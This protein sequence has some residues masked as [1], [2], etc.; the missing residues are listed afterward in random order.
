MWTHAAAAV[1][2]TDRMKLLCCCMI[3]MKK[4]F[5]A[6]ELREACGVAGFNAGCI[7][8]VCTLPGHAGATKQKKII[9]H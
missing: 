9:K 7:K 5:I 6:A 8:A 3:G 2:E 1:T 4:M